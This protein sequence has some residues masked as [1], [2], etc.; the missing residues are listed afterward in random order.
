M[1]FQRGPTGSGLGLGDGVLTFEALGAGGTAEFSGEAGQSRG[2]G[3]NYSRFRLVGVLKAHAHGGVGERRATENLGSYGG[4]SS[5]G[6]LVSTGVTLW[7]Q[8]VV[9][10]LT[11]VLGVYGGK[12]TKQK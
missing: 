4:L 12:K 5:P 3:Q 7:S 2:L 11:D 8:Q 6:D 1:G 9:F 10:R